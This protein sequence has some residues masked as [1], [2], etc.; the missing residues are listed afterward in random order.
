MTS[1]LAI[2]GEPGA[3]KSTAAEFLARGGVRLSA[4]AEVHELWRTSLLKNWAKSRWGKDVFDAS[5]NIDMRQ[6]SLRIFSD[7][8]DYRALCDFINPL[9]FAAMK[10]KLPGNG[11]VIAEIP[12]LFEAG[13][14]D[15]VDAVLFVA[16]GKNARAARNSFRGLDETELS[17]RERFFMSRGERIAKS[18]YVVC[19]DGTKEEFFEKLK[20]VKT[21]FMTKVKEVK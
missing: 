19:N 14:P 9:V 3:G 2:T 4:D 12:M 7:V 20:E 13:V 21:K 11:I 15:W 10:E 6:I 5:G 8:A 17:R 18:D 16:A 1:V